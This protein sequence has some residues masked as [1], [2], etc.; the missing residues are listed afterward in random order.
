[1]DIQIISASAGSG[2]TYRLAELLEKEVR[3][4][5]VRPDAILATTFTKKA[6]AELQERVRT[7]LLAAGLSTEAQ[8]LAASRIGTVNSVCGS[9]L[10]D[11]SFDLGISPDQKVIEEEA[12]SGVIGKAM[13]R[14][15]DK[16]ISKELW[17]LE[18]RFPETDTRKIIEIII[19]KA[20]ANGLNDVELR[21]CGTRSVA[22]SLNLFGTAST[23]GAELDSGLSKAIESFLQAVDLTVD[24]TN[25]TKEAVDMVDRLKNTLHFQKRLPWSDWLRLSKLAPGAKSRDAA[26]GIIAAAGHHDHHPELHKDVSRLID[27]VFT[28]AADTLSVY[29]EYK[30]EWGIVDF[31][32][33]EALVLK[34]LEQEQPAQIISE[35][36]DL[37]LVDEFQDTSPIELAI[38]LKLARLAKKSVWVGDQ[39]QAIYGFRDADPSLMDAAITGILGNTEP[40]TLKKS[41][42]SRPE[43]VRSTSDIFVQSFAAQGFPEQR[44]RLEPADK[45]VADEPQGLSPIYECWELESKNKEQDASAL[46]SAVR[47]FLVDP[48]NSIR[49]PK[50]GGKRNARGGDVAILCRGN[51]VC[52][53]VAKALE[54]QGIEAALPR[55]GLLDCPEVILTLAATRLLIDSKDSLAR[56]EIARLLDNPGNHEGW[57]EKAL[58][59][60]YSQGFDLEEFTRLE[61][62]KN[63]LP[64]AG[65][66]PFLDAA[67]ESVRVRRCCLAWGQSETRLANLDVLR[68]LCVNYVEECRNAGRG[69]SPSGML[70]HLENLSTATRAVVQDENT[71]QVLTWHKA[72][73]LEWPVTVLFQLDKVYPPTPLGV[74][75]VSDSEFNLE[76]PLA[77]RW[78]RYWPN[79]YG[80]SRTGAPFHER[81]LAGSVMSACTEKEERQ[82]LRLLYVGW[83][84]ARDK[85][86]LAGRSGFLQK[87]ILRL[88]KDSDGKHLLQPSDKESALWAG[89]QVTMVNRVGV[90]SPPVLKTIQPGSGYEVAG[91]KE[92]PPAFQAASVVNGE[93]TVLSS[94]SLGERLSL[95]GV[96]DMQAM[97]EAIHSF[98][99]VDV[100]T[101]EKG[102][103]LAL[104]EA[105]LAR[106]EVTP[107]LTTTD[108]LTASDRLD[109][110]INA[111]WPIAK[112]HHEYPVALRHENGTIVS[113]FIDLL[114]ETQEGFVIIDHKSFPGSREEAGKKAANFAGQ[115]GLY[116]EATETATG[117]KVN[118]Q[119]IYLPLIGA[120]MNVQY[121]ECKT[122]GG[123]NE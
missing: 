104:A 51:D 50:T 58:S 3:E 72:K 81:L 7:K 26:A 37:V 16:T 13:S 112:R 48:D 108:L 62:T 32:D 89:R 76:D 14:V 92:Y 106:W 109:T 17:Q 54:E 86:V 25:K 80:K 59:M 29:Q 68:S 82:E 53:Q 90:P 66:L 49:D 74:H 45:V 111:K 6:A 23:N 98:L 9:L 121:N 115:L 102:K 67:M 46:A 10:T 60:P 28:L 22:G 71:V 35:Q 79:P 101:R 42:R 36:L 118:S 100:V 15:I 40:E 55:P 95:I 39:K 123:L 84:R 83:T 43:L 113:G 120:S 99:A 85:V 44:V 105:I 114:L 122:V 96:P 88:L 87:G 110:W 2:K 65:P 103:R 30:R 4:K 27:L 119:W 117:R 18:Q 93:G 70:A 33:Q 24:T 19:A 20:R 1:M 91:P 34:L 107:N 75:V 38:F 41:W 73:G 8:Q 12:V 61:E 5:Q 116:A 78:L 69:A 47:E 52:V 94:E 97:G 57:L 77:N 56:A 21:Q 64:M 63:A 11:F 31:I